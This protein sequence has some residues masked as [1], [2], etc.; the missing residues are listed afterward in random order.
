MAFRE[1]VTVPLISKAM[2]SRGA[3][4]LPGVIEDEAAAE[5]FARKE[6]EFRFSGYAVVADVT[7][8]TYDE[9]HTEWHF[10]FNV[11]GT[12]YHPRIG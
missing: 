12:Y 2:F 3:D 1:S 7:H 5:A 6:L 10:D 11:T 8:V 4:E 9:K